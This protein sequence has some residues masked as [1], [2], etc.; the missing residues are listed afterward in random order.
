MQQEE[1]SYIWKSRN[2]TTAGTI[3][4]ENYHGVMF[5]N[6]GDKKAYINDSPIATLKGLSFVDSNILHKD[7]SQYKISFEAGATLT[8]VVMWYREIQIKNC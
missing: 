3:L 1:I 8:Q 7:N 2:I 5:H 4:A 6:A